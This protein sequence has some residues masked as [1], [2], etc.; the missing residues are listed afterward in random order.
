MENIIT[1]LYLL[2]VYQCIILA[3]LLLAVKRNRTGRSTLILGFFFLAL[4]IYFLFNFLYRIKAFLALLWIYP[5]ILPVIVAIIPVFYL[6]IQSIT[7]NRNP[8]T[9]SGLLHLFPSLVILLLNSYFYTLPFGTR[10]G[11]ISEGPHLTGMASGLKYLLWVYMISIYVICNLQLIFYLIRVMKVYRRYKVYIGD[12]Y[13]YTENIDITWIKNFIIA[14]VTLFLINN[15]LYIIGFKQHPVSQF[16]YIASM[17]ALTLYAGIQGLKQR[18]PEIRPG[19]IFPEAEQEQDE[20]VMPGA[21]ALPSERILQEEPESDIQDSGTLLPR[22]PEKYSGS[23]LTGELKEKLIER[24]EWF[25]EN[26]KIYLKDD[27]S[28]EDVAAKLESNSKYVS[29]VIN[30]HYGKNFFNYINGFRIEEA[31]RIMLESGNDKYSIHGIAR[32]VGFVSK[33][34]FNIAFKKFTGKTPSEFKAGKDA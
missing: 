26:E 9:L 15:T 25:I 12:H 1:S 6:Y 10:L 7:G 29:Q 20:Q 24:L 28:I 33:S 18:E 22:Q 14:L 11:Y 5:L 23:A 4:T 3:V 32:M 19:V 8:F 31:K 27:L 2:P 16:F 34:S 30:E 17:L 21:D 13:S